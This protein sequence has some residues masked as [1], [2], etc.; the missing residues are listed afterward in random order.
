M[1]FSALARARGGL[2]ASGLLCIDSTVMKYYLL[3][4]GRAR[5]RAILAWYYDKLE[6]TVS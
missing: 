4:G 2:P 6:L 3:A 5:A 1:I